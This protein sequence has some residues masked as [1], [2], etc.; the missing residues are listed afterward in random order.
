MLAID[1]SGSMAAL[2][3]N[4]PQPLTDVK[5]AAVY[6]VNQLDENDIVGMVS[7]ATNAGTSTESLLS[8]DTGLIK[9]AIDNISIGTQGIQ[10][11]NITEAL[12]K[13]LEELSSS[14]K[15]DG[16]P[17][18]MVLLTDGVATFP[19]KSGE[20]DYPE[21]SALSLGQLIKDRGIRLFTIGLGKDLNEGFL[22][23]L[24]SSPDDFYLAPT[25]KE[26]NEIYA[27]IA[28]KICQKKP[29]VIEIIPRIFPRP[30]T[31]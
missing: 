21:S 29:A 18:V 5:N 31:L 23:S 20:P 22:T 27:Q 8:S 7:F 28:T 2:G 17:S 11:T 12:S 24:A 6:F 19:Q 15:R 13:S 25:A 9:E 10:Q 26:L 16:I 30:V 1:R 14:R 3:A 4:P